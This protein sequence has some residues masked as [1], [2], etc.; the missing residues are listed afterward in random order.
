[1][2]G[3]L[4]L[5]NVRSYIMIAAG[6]SA[7]L[8]MFVTFDSGHTFAN[9]V[10]YFGANCVRVLGPYIV[11]FITVPITWALTDSFGAI[12]AGVLWPISGFWV[13]LMVFLIM[14]SFIA[15]LFGWTLDWGRIFNMR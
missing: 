11:S 9:T 14:F 1:V 10:N 3:I 2:L 4:A 13:I 5:I 7:V 6:F 8:L 12:V 15:P